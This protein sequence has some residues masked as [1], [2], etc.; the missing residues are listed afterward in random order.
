LGAESAALRQNLRGVEIDA[1]SVISAGGRLRSHGLDA[2]ILN[3]DFFDQKP[4]RQFD[5]VIG[6]PPF[7]R[8]Q[9]FFGSARTKGLQAALAQGVRLTSLASS[10]AA[11]TVHAAEF[12]NAQGRLAFVLPAE[13]LSVNYASDVRRFLLNRFAKVRLILFDNLIFPGVLEE[14]VLLLAEGTGSAS[15]FEVYQARDA[16][17][18]TRLDTTS[19]RDFTPIANE[20]WTPA[21]MDADALETYRLATKSSGFTRL[22]AWGET[23]LGAVTGNNDYFTLTASAVARH[24]LNDADVLKI[25]PPGARHLRGLTFSLSAWNELVRED[26]RCFLFWPA[27]GRLSKSAK[28]YIKMGEELGVNTAYKCRV[29]SGWLSTGPFFHIHES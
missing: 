3:A 10:W 25:S 16:N 24:K 23:S 5:V 29:R 28:A 2:V 6:N 7:V 20:K 27:P 4:E 19:W 8:Y 21:L 14:V 26:S 12:L 1:S 9:S 17:S 11:F 13:L 15:N 18:L 22:Q